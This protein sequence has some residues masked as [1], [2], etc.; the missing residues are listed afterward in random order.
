MCSPPLMANHHPRL[1]KLARDLA[2]RKGEI[3]TLTEREQVLLTE[4]DEVRSQKQLAEQAAVLLSTKIQAFELDAD[5][6]RVIQARPR[7]KG[8][9]YG[10]FRKTL[11]QTLQM[12]REPLSTAEILEILQAV[13]DP[14][15]KL[16]DGRENAMHRIA[17]ELRVLRDSGWV[18]RTDGGG[19][20]VK[21]SWL[22]I[23]ER[24]TVQESS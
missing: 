9:R 6:V 12:F 17:H 19:A 7:K 5:D 11:A 1:A 15:L 20:G 22:W 2:Y 24:P 21:A 16:P 4:L 14:G 13:E 8:A 23:G 3:L 18:L 10:S